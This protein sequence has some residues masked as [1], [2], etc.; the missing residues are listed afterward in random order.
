MTIYK[1]LLKALAAAGWVE[2]H[3]TIRWA[4]Y[5]LPNTKDPELKDYALWVPIK[6]DAPDFIHC[7]VDAIDSF[8]EISGTQI[9]PRYQ[10]L[11]TSKRVSECAEFL[12]MPVK[13]FLEAG[14]PEI[15]L[16]RTIEQREEKAFYKVDEQR[17]IFSAGLI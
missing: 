16:H 4:A 13:E 2:H 3:R 1:K 5:W 14:Y 15:T 6:E 12:G 9:L 8:E 17:N 7:L 10:F 11:G